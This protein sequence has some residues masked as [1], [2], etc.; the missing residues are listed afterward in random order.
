MPAH[1]SPNPK[2]HRTDNDEAANSKT[3][4]HPSNSVLYEILMKNNAMLEELHKMFQFQFNEDNVTKAEL[5]D[6]KTAYS[7]LKNEHA[8]LMKN[9]EEQSKVGLEASAKEIRS[10]VQNAEQSIK[11]SLSKVSEKISSSPAAKASYSAALKQSSSV[12]LIRPKDQTQTSD[13]TKSAVRQSIDPRKFPIQGVRN[14]NKG[15][16]IIEC[17]SKDSIAQ[18][19]EDAQK[20]LGAD[21]EIVTQPDLRAIWSTMKC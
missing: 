15:G 6:L 13:S 2:R 20:N 4:S 17:N 9:Y 11:S 18:L 19:K 3:D 7:E 16:I 5:A 8:Q 21:Y 1:H 10:S 14:V 12:V